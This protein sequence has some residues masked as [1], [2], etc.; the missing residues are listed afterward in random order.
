M[1]FTGA[2]VPPTR[3]MEPTCPRVIGI[4]SPGRILATSFLRMEAMHIR[5]QVVAAVGEVEARVELR[6]ELTT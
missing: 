4:C 5:E 6:V 3:G 1:G 2:A